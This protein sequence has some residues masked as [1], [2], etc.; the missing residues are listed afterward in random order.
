MFPRGEMIRRNML[1]MGFLAE[2]KGICHGLTHTWMQAALLED[3]AVFFARIN[4]LSHDNYVKQAKL[5]QLK[6][7]GARE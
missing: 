4:M 3:E 2:I 6:V 1:G 7:D 5:V